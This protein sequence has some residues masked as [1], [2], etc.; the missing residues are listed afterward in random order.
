MTIERVYSNADLVFSV[1]KDKST[2]HHFWE[3]V[4]GTIGLL[5][6]SSPLTDQEVGD[7]KKEPNSIK[8]LVKAV[9]GDPTK[10]EEERPV[11][12]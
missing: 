12:H 9:I 3:V 2:G 4:C 8:T 5:E 6:V 7:F 11:T 10:F 1:L